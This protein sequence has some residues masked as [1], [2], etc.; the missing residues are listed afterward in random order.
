MSCWSLCQG[1]DILESVASSIDPHGM[2]LGTPLDVHW[3][4]GVGDGLPQDWDLHWP[5]SGSK[6]C[7]DHKLREKKN[8]WVSSNSRNLRVKEEKLISPDISA[9]L[10]YGTWGVGGAEQVWLE[11]PCPQDRKLSFKN[12]WE[13]WKPMEPPYVHDFSCVFLRF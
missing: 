6:A 2:S 1:F 11:Q 4:I 10:W 12:W 5:A 3:M 7:E 13:N 8:T 9:I